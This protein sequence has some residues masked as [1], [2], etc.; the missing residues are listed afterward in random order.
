M[1]F[2]DAS[3]SISDFSCKINNAFIYDR[4]PATE[5]LDMYNNARDEN[6]FAFVAALV[7]ELVCAKQLLNIK[8]R[9]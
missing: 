3:K 8:G 7:T 2:Q 9:E 5:L 4:V 6:K 1:N